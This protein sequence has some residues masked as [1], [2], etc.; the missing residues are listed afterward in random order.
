MV[1]GWMADKRRRLLKI[2]LAA[3]LL[4]SLSRRIDMHY[5]RQCC[6]TTIDSLESRAIIFSP[7]TPAYCS[8]GD[9]STA[10]FSPAGVSGAEKNSIRLSSELN[11]HAFAAPLLVRRQLTQ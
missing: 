5:P 11:E 6:A 9:G 7:A 10:M 2:V 4:H 1:N 8:R 3:T